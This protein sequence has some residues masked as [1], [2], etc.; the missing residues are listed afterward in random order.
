VTLGANGRVKSASV[1]KGL[2]D[3][4]NEKAIEAAYRL[5]FEPARNG[6]GV[7]I[8]STLTVSVNFTIR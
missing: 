6:A 8:D 2:P 5:S 4:L 1:V 7:P 3:G